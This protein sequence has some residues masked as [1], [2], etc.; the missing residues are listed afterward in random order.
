MGPAA[1]WMPSV[2]AAV[3]G[4]AATSVI[5]SMLQKA[6]AGANVTMAAAP[7]PAATPTMPTPDS[8]AIKDAQALSIAQQRARRGRAS[9]ILTTGLGDLGSGAL[10]G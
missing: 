3:A 8:K 7:T 5:S 1:A 9:T 4:G 2:I 10:G 6:P